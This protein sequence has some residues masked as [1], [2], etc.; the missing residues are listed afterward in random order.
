TAQSA[1][2]RRGSPAG[3]SRGR[4]RS[5]RGGAMAKPPK[6]KVMKVNLWLRVEGVN[7][8]Y[9]G[10]SA[11]LMIRGCQPAPCSPFS[12]DCSASSNRRRAYF[13]KSA[14]EPVFGA[15]SSKLFGALHAI[16]W[17]RVALYHEARGKYRLYFRRDG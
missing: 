13:I 10:S 5:R 11:L 12:R 2:S 6:P 15:V 9:L 7:P 4:G 8:R 17:A 14:E 1:K 16:T 3:R